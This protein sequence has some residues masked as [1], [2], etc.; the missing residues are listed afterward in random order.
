[1][2][3]EICKYFKGS[4][5]VNFAQF[6][7]REESLY[8]FIQF[9][10]TKYAKVVS[11]MTTH[12][13][14]TC[15]LSVQASRD[16][17]QPDFKQENWTAPPQQDSQSHIL[18]AL[19][20]DCLR[21]IFSRLKWIDLCKAAEVCVRFNQLAK[22]A[23]AAKFKHLNFSF[24]TLDVSIF[25]NDEELSQIPK[26]L[27]SNFGSFIQSL[28]VDGAIIK[29][30]GCPERGFNF[31]RMIGHYCNSNLKELE[32]ERFKMNR[33]F[34]NEIYH[35]FAKLER[36]SLKCCYF[37]NNVK[38]LKS[39]LS[40]CNELKMMIIYRCEIKDWECITQKFPKLNDIY[41]IENNGFNMSYLSNFIVL[42]PT[43]TKLSFD[44][45]IEASEV[46]RLISQNL[47][48]LSELEFDSDCAGFQGNIRCLGQLRSLNMLA[49][50]L[51]SNLMTSLMASLVMNKVPIQTLRL[52]DGKINVETID[53]ISQLK[54]IK[55]LELVKVSGMVSENLIELA[56]RLPQIK[57]FLSYKT[58]ITITISTLKKMISN[59]CNLTQLLL[60]GIE[61]IGAIDIDDYK[62]M[63]TLVR[64]R[65]KKL[66]ICLLDCNHLS[67]ITVPSE[68]LNENQ[69]FICIKE[70]L[71]E[72]PT[73]DEDSDSDWFLSDYIDLE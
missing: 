12:S 73:Y 9:L 62:T 4:G 8:G 42:N 13:L 58:P 57:R 35:I 49:L 72:V 45:Y 39:L 14:T 20:D 10:D 6:N 16:C 59:A 33:N 3:K 19:N 25:F 67:H 65:K 68:V 36:L 23:F 56:K 17:H 22:E 26:I 18:I 55:N 37:T 29:V 60:E 40:T 7:P 27:L 44:G 53:L 64:N 30:Y 41:L 69:D 46:F 1:M 52:W 70:R 48:N 61:L 66:D 2:I 31:L 51:G 15:R 38:N 43:I 21:E 34:P 63:L 28:H 11:P 5:E 71:K 50:D 47:P 54:Q 24:V 32:L